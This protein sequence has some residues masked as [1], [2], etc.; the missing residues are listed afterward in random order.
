MYTIIQLKKYRLSHV[1]VQCTILYGIWKFLYYFALV[2]HKT[3]ET[4]F[5]KKNQA[6]YFQML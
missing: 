3:G 6:Y 1:K 4:L 2:F 5:R